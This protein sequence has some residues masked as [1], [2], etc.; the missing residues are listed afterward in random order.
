MRKESEK[1]A[2]AFAKRKPATAKRTSTDGE[3]VTLHVNTIAWWNADGSLSLTL[4][5]WPTA[6]TRDRL[7]AI[8]E[9]LGYG[10]PF[11]QKRNVQYHNE[12]EINEHNT[13]TYHPLRMVDPEE[14]MARNAA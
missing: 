14:W 8:C 3:K 1:I 9:V 6:T 2:L 7:N 10:R 5:G 4:A 12:T 13:I 11:H